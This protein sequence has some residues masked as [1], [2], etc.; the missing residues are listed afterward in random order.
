MDIN[1][2]RQLLTLLAAC[3]QDDKLLGDIVLQKISRGS[4]YQFIK[5]LDKYS[6]FTSQGAAMYSRI[7]Q[8][9]L[10]EG[11]TY[12]AACQLETELSRLVSEFKSLLSQSEISAKAAFVSGY[13]DVHLLP[14]SALTRIMEEK[15]QALQAGQL[16]KDWLK[17]NDYVYLSD[18]AVQLKEKMDSFK[19]QPGSL[20]ELYDLYSQLKSFSYMLH[21]NA[22]IITR[23]KHQSNQKEKIKKIIKN[24]IIAAVV[25]ALAVIID[26]YWV[27]I[28]KVV[29]T[30]VTWIVGCSV[31]ALIGYLYEK[32]FGKG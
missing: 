10:P 22:D 8:F 20:Q 27:T 18:A 19:L 31:L 23:Q 15:L 7:Q 16:Y 5:N 24:I 32:I 21:N 4:D 12:F 29:K 28:V 2:E 14:T 1:P 17:R 30:A 11:A 26:K 3:I 25:I 9:K 13:K 6:C